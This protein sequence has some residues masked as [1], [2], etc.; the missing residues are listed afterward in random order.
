MKPIK[1]QEPSIAS[2]AKRDINENIPCTHGN[3]D[4][5]RVVKLDPIAASL[6]VAGLPMKGMNLG[7]FSNIKV[8]YH[9]DAEYEN[10][11][12]HSEQNNMSLSKV[13]LSNNGKK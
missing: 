4:G 1:P 12:K 9:A 3:K 5:V 11:L 7:I 8:E 13:I 6:L 2:T 10:P